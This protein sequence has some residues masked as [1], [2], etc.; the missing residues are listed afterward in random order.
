MTDNQKTESPIELRVAALLAER[1]QLLARLAEMNRELEA[2]GIAV[3][4]AFQLLVD[5]SDEEPEDPFD[6]LPV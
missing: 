4:N 5:A 3:P 6:N 2:M 1:R